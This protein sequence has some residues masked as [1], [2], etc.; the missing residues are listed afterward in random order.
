M[1]ATA[2]KELEGVAG[3]LEAPQ[4]RVVA[5]CLAVQAAQV[6][7]AHIQRSQSTQVDQN[8][9]EIRFITCIIMYI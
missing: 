3:E 2:V 1:K 4:L 5:E 9:L 7:V 6:V 8:V